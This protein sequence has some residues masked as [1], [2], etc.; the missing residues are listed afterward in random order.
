VIIRGVPKNDLLEEIFER[1]V[2]KV[3]QVFFTVYSYQV[4]NEL[5][6]LF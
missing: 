1:L 2:G 4:E 5:Q 6:E 3:P